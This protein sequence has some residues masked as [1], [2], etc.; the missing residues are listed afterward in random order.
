[1]RASRLSDIARQLCRG[2]EA[3]HSAN[4]LHQDLKSNNAMLTRRQDGSLRVVITDFGLALALGGMGGEASGRFGGTPNYIAPER[5]KGAAATPASDVYALGVVLYEMLAGRLPFRRDTPWAERLTSLPE[6]PSRSERHPDPRW[7]AIVLRCMAPDPARRFSSAGE[8]LRAIDGAFGVRNRKRWLAAAVLAVALASPVAVLRERIWPPPVARLAILPFEGSTGD[9]QIDAAAKGAL[10]GLAGRVESL[11]AS[12]RLAIIPM[13]EALRQEADAPELAAARLGATHVLTGAFLPQGAGF[14]VRAAVTDART[15]V[16]LRDYTGEFG[17]G[18]TAALPDSLSGVVSS[19]FRLDRPPPVGVA[20]GAY[21]HYA[22]GVAALGGVPPDF[23][24][25]IG[26]FDE[27]LKADGGSA[28]IY[29]GLADARHRKWEVVREPGLLAKAKESA[30]RAESLQPDCAAVLLAAGFIEATDGRPERALEMFQR[31]VELEPGN[32]EIW[33][34][35]GIVQQRLGREADAVASLQ[36]A[37]QLA[38]DYYANHQALGAIYFLFGRYADAAD[39]FRAVTRLA[40][41]LPEGHGLLGAALLTL[42]RD[43]EAE[44]ALRKALAIRETRATLNNLGIL[45]AYGRRFEETVEV[46]RRALKAGADDARLRLNLGIALRRIER[47]GEAREQF[48]RASVLAREMLLR[49][50]R[51]AVARAQLSYAMVRLGQSALAA[52]EA[53]QAGRLAPRDY[54]VLYW[55]VMTLDALGRRGDALALLAE[56]S[57]ERL[58]DMRRQPDLADFARD[59]RFLAL[60]QQAQIQPAKGENRNASRNR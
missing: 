19:A 13:D 22:A 39:A 57:P 36:R 18:D 10:R 50:P 2:L 1:M 4:I 16:N 44:A 56:A 59:P 49:D 38:P 12:R 48:E 47:L 40:P 30:R 54:S 21:S 20:P 29:A 41:E 24:K 26:S 55:C 45:L 42:E 6:P 23:D 8:V 7:D 5:W 9:G 51:N 46:L 35:N 28:L 3:A 52:D 60:L 17:A 53:L 58:R 37:V 15:G 31:A 32:A 14:A 33:R 43:A 27:A 25:A 11:G 34:R